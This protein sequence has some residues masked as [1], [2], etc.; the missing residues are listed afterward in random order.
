MT[1][2]IYKTNTGPGSVDNNRLIY[3]PV[4]AENMKQLNIIIVLNGNRFKQCI[5]HAS[6]TTEGIYQEKL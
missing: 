6:E 3:L 1:K 2:L 4:P 5:T